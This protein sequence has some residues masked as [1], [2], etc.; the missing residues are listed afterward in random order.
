VKKWILKT[1]LIRTTLL[2][3][4]IASILFLVFIGLIE[5]NEHLCRNEAFLKQNRRFFR[6]C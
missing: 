2:F 5:R 6:F 3:L 1:P 4:D